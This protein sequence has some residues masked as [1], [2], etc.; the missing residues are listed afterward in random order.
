MR[1]FT[2]SVT[3]FRDREPGAGYLLPPRHVLASATSVTPEDLSGET[4]LLPEAPESGAA[5]T[6]DSSSASWERREWCRRIRW[7]S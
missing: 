4:I 3:Y 5:L 1:S 2:Q 6:G 7:S